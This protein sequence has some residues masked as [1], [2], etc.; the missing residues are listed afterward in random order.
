MLLG[1]QQQKPQSAATGEQTPL[2]K[3]R[4]VAQLDL[5]QIKERGK[6]VALLNYSSTSY[7][8]YRG[9]P[10]GFEYEL[11]KRLANELDVDLEIKLANNLNEITE[12]LLRGE[13]DIIAQGL[14]VT[15]KR[16]QYLDFTRRTL[17]TRQV[18][19]QKM[20]D[21][22]R[23]MKNHQLE[24]LMIRSTTELAGKKI[25]VREGSSYYQR[26]QNLSDEIGDDIDLR[27]AP[28]N[29]QTEELIRLVAEGEIPYTVADENIARVQKTYLGNIDIKTPVSF[30]QNIAWAVR[31]SSPQLKAAIN[32]WLMEI[33]QTATFNSLYARYFKN[34][35]SFRKRVKSDFYSKAGGQLSEYDPL[36]KKYASQIDWDWRLLASLMYQESRFDP[37]AESWAGAKGL[38]QVMPVT[39]KHFGIE[40]LNH[41]ESNM[42]AGIAYLSYLKKYW[43]VIPDS[44]QRLKFI[45]AS[46]NAG[47]G[48]VSD[49]RRLAKKY[50]KN[51]NFWDDNVETYILKKSKPR[52]YNDEVVKY[53]Y[54]RGYEPYTYVRRILQRHNHY[55]EILDEQKGYAANQQKRTAWF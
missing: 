44:V 19:V 6:L 50:G 36:I 23:R 52:Y 15:K 3:E 39:G 29:L 7:F 43:T 48:H 16:R 1:C 53:G 28:G 26:L 45:L 47:H 17:K 40:N 54:V 9:R 51:P 41:P 21:N 8:I 12:M 27:A 10:M 34:S 4:R 18:L 14:T 33:K 55:T 25:Y 46:Y 49:A 24:K 38:M 37:L 11:L 22:W 31:K 42:R 5:P 30:S 35:R 32:K 13:G 20:P 2:V